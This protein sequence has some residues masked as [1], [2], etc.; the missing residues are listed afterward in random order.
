MASFLESAAQSVNRMF[1]L[2]CLFVVL[3]VSYSGFEDGNLVLIP[4][5]P[6]NCFLYV[7]LCTGEVRGALDIS[8]M[9]VCVSIMSH[10]VQ[11]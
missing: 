7:L 9:S 6:G 5:V 11:R 8:C 4:P 1:S 10:I 3:V 2:L